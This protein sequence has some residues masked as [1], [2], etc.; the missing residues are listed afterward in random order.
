MSAG[1]ADEIARRWGTEI[2]TTYFLAYDQPLPS[3]IWV[4]VLKIVIRKA[5]KS[6]RNLQAE[7][8]ALGLHRAIDD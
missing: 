3:A 4:L 7:R 5:W 6:G 1:L 8:H 2:K